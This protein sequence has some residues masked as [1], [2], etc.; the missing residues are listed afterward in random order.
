MMSRNTLTS[1]RILSSAFK[2]VTKMQAFPSF[3][4]TMG[5]FD[6]NSGEVIILLKG[7]ALTSTRISSKAISF[8]IRDIEALR[9]AMKDVSAI[10]MSNYVK[11]VVVCF[12]NHVFNFFPLSSNLGNTP[13]TPSR[14]SSAFRLRQNH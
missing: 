10:A 1:T 11:T 8:V 12:S 14:T 5:K 3:Q 6:R 4:T 7:N 9:I 2:C 13:F